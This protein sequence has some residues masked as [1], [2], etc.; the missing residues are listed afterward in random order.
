MLSPS[1]AHL[2]VTLFEAL[3]YDRMENGRTVARSVG[4][5]AGR[6]NDD[7]DDRD[8]DECAHLWRCP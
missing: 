8:G 1:S 5:P 4:W 7:D 2:T 3:V 6:L